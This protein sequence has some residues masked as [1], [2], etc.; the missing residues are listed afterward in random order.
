M[1][2]EYPDGVRTL[3]PIAPR[4]PDCSNEQGSSAMAD[5]TGA[6][7]HAP[8]SAIIHP[9]GQ[10]ADRD[11]NHSRNNSAEGSP[12]SALMGLVPLKICRKCGYQGY[13]MACLIS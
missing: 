5:N 4:E 12:M 9:C 1:I 6:I 2:S 8:L 3:L 11:I 7:T 13:N 10:I